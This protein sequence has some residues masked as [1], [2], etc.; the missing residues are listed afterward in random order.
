MPSQPDFYPPHLSLPIVRICQA[1]APWLCHWQYHMRLEVDSACLQTLHSLDGNRVI[2]MPNHPTFHDWV[3]VFLLSAKIPMAFHYLAAYERFH[4]MGGWWLQRLG[5][6]SIRRGLGDRPSVAKTLELMM[7]PAC[8]LVIF[9]EGGCSF[10]NDTVMPFRAG[11]VQVAFQAMNKLVRQGEPVPDLYAVPLS[12]KYYY[13]SD[14]TLVIHN[15]LTRL[16]RALRLPRAETPYE[17][18]R[19]VAEQVLQGLERDYDFYDDTN[20]QLSWNERIP[21][22]RNHVLQSCEQQLGITPGVNDLPRERVYRIQYT[23]ESRAESF[24]GADFWTYNSIHTAAARL[25]NFDAI[26]DGYVAANPTPERFLDTLTRLERA[27]FQIDQPPPKGYR[28]VRVKV[29]E[30]MNLKDY[31]ERYQGDRPT[32]VD[33]LTRELQQQVQTHLNQATLTQT[34]NLTP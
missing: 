16:E 34:T 14:M 10:Q 33:T 7:Q 13:T 25:L 4:G 6:Y 23:L 15:T 11:A 29:G 5:A 32:T 27:V 22:L 26:Y 20:H 19:V 30:P 8:R 21:Q 28:R 9:P 3:A 17:R 18:L 12:L 2:L 1:I 31:F 24:T